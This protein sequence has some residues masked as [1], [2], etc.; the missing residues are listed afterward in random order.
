MTLINTYYNVASTCVTGLLLGSSSL[1][2]IVILTR[3]RSFFTISGWNRI[4][5]SLPRIG[6]M[7]VIR[8]V[9]YSQAEQL[10]YEQTKQ[11]MN[12]YDEDA[13]VEAGPDGKPTNEYGIQDG[14]EKRGPHQLGRFIR[15][16]VCAVKVKFGVPKRND[17]NRMAVRDYAVRIMKEV[18]HRPSHI[19]RDVPV[20]VRLVF[21]PT[22]EEL[23]QARLE[24]YPMAELERVQYEHALGRREC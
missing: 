3:A 1:A 10:H 2:A 5:Y 21:Q 16:V 23:V 15:Q 4:E 12:K 14:P 19:I 20:V 24:S 17:A 11:L 7:H 6:L 8:K 18:G 13:G 9:F 22:D